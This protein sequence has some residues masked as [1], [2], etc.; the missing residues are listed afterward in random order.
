MPVQPPRAPDDGNRT[1]SVLNRTGPNSARIASV[2]SPNAGTVPMTGSCPAAWTA[3]SSASMSPP[4]VR[5]GRQRPR[6]RSSGCSVS[7][8][9]VR[10]RAQAIPAS[11]SAAMTSSAVCLAKE[12]SMIA[13]SSSLRAARSGLLANRGSA[14]RS[15]RRSTSLQNTS[16]SLSF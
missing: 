4:G 2:C 7:S 9:G 8:P 16:H 14:A 6:A 10:N 12:S 1:R 3:G 15:P 5:T 13:V 11:S